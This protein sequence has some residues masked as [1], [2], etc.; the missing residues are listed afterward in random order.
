[1]SI[2]AGLPVPKW[3]NPDEDSHNNLQD[4]QELVAGWQSIQR[5]KDEQIGAR[6]GLQLDQMKQNLNLNQTEMQNQAIDQQTIP[7][8]LQQNNTWDKRNAATDMPVPLSDWGMKTMQGIRIGDAQ[9]IGKETMLRSTEDFTKRFHQLTPEFSSKIIQLP[10]GPNGQPSPQQWDALNAAE[11]IMSDRDMKKKQDA[12]IAIKTEQEKLAEQLATKKA[13]DSSALETQR[14][15]ERTTRDSQKHQWVVENIDHR[16]DLSAQT[17]AKKFTN[18]KNLAKFNQEATLIRSS[19]LSPEQQ[20]SRMKDLETKYKSDFGG[21]GAFHDFEDDGT[22]KD[23]AMSTD[24]K[25]VKV[26]SPNGQVGTI[27]AEQLDYALKQGYKQIQ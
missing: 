24:K 17:A 22:P 4:A 1:M 7:A 18:Q 6:T 21:A 9:N 10:G 27:P 5:Q 11:S 3:S 2:F 20:V 26:K 13:T 15:T 12:Q 19:Q 25:T 14:S 8:W 23:S 16:Y